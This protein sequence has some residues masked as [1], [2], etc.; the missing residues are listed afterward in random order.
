MNKRS[1]VNMKKVSALLIVALL[2]LSGIASVMAQGTLVSGSTVEVKSNYDGFKNFSLVG[3]WSTTPSLDDQLII[4]NA[5]LPEPYGLRDEIHIDVM[6]PKVEQVFR[7]GNQ[8]ALYKPAFAEKRYYY[9]TLSQNQDV[10][11][12]KCNTELESD[13]ATNYA[14]RQIYPG[15]FPIGLVTGLY[16]DVQFVVKD[17]HEGWVGEATNHRLNYYQDISLDGVGTLHLERSEAK[18][19]LVDRINGVGRASLLNFGIWT[20]A[21]LS[22]RNV[23]AYH[24]KNELGTDKWQPFQDSVG[25]ATYN[26]AQSLIISKFQEGGALLAP[27]DKTKVTESIAVMKVEVDRLKGA[28]FTIPSSWQGSFDGTPRTAANDI[29]VTIAKNRPTLVPQIQLVLAGEK[30]GL[31][32]PTGKPKILS[33]DA[34]ISFDETKSGYINYKV[35]NIGSARGA[36]LVKA[37]CNDDRVVSAENELNINK[38][39]VLTGK[40]QVTAKSTQFAE[41]E[42]V[43]CKIRMTETNTQEFVEKDVKISIIVKELCVEGEQTDP[44]LSG[45]NYVVNVLDKTCNIKS[46]LS[47][48]KVDKEFVKENGLWVCKDKSIF[49]GTGG[50]DTSNNDD[51]GSFSKTV[52]I[53]AIVLALIVGLI[54]FGFTMGLQKIP[55]GIWIQLVLSIGAAVLIFFAVPLIWGAIVGLFTFAT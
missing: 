17:T 35:Q 34:T 54:V 53:I 10:R 7:V 19:Q 6:A 26:S 32:I 25:I 31:F 36:F 45:D 1:S 20:N 47:C 43:S 39:Q 22:D 44:V 21:Q 41:T 11:M 14:G 33:A 18:D 51:N 50:G 40:L 27:A 29:I 49:G 37:F 55:Y 3:T 46:S 9:F 48:P 52:L 16:C 5:N 4:T 8:K 24:A 2:L 12:D 23:W 30:F 38:D 42:D 15:T 13:L 28:S